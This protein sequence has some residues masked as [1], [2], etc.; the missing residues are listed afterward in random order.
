MDKLREFIRAS[1]NWSRIAREEDLFELAAT[2]LQNVLRIDAGMMV[3]KKQHV[4]LQDNQVRVYCKWGINESDEDLVFRVSQD[5]VWFTQEEFIQTEKWLA[6]EDTI[7]PWKEFWTTYG[8]KQI[9]VWPI[10]I[11]DKSAGGIVLGRTVGDF[12]DDADTVSLCATQ[13]SLILDML[14]MRR[15]VEYI[16]F[17]DPLTNILNRRGF[18]KKITH[19][20]EHTDDARNLFVG[21]LDIDN[22]K[23]INDTH[24]HKHGDSVLSDIADILK[25][26]IGHEGFCARF[27]GDEFVFVMNNVQ[28]STAFERQVESWFLEKSYSVSVGC[29]DVLSNGYDWEASFK[30]ADRRLYTNK[31]QKES[32]A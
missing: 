16:S 24:G 32:L 1:R 26:K 11:E 23:F 10:I 3:C 5:G 2:A 30:V 13:V 9:G 29:A 22:F 19:F 17:H 18:V 4:F 28:D 27:G 20:E 7:Q 6:V 21:T 14:T 8:I 15:Q 31:N 12:F 25:S